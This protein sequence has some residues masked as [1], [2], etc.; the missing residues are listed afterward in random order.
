MMLCKNCSQEVHTPDHLT[1]EI[2]TSGLYAC[3]QGIK[4]NDPRWKLVAE[5]VTVDLDEDVPE[6]S[7]AM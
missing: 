6:Y 2:H 5:G 4:M 3:H 1:G 7:G